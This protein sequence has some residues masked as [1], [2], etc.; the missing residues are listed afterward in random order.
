M[1]YCNLEIP[2]GEGE[3][4]VRLRKDELLR[5]RENR[6]AKF[7]RRKNFAICDILI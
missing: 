1:S 7:S 6:E 5:I 2:G 3:V 4:E